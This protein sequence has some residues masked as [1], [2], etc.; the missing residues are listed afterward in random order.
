MPD[1]PEGTFFEELKRR[2]VFRVAI[3][4]AIASWLILQI[5]DVVVPMLGLPEWVG[6]MVLLMLIVSFPIALI[7]AWA[8]E[9]TPEGVRLERNVDRSQSITAQTGKKLNFIIIGALAVALGISLYLNFGD[10]DEEVVDTGAA[11][12]AGAEQLAPSI[13]VLPFANRSANENDTFFVDGMHDD[14][15]TQLAKIPALK[16]IS[17]TSVL[18]YR[19][20][21]KPMTIIG[22]ELGVTTIVEG[23]VQRAGDRIRI[24][25]QLI[26]AAT[27]EHIWAET[28]NR[29]LTAANIFEIQEEVT[30]EIAAAL[31]AEL[32]P[33]DQQRLAVIPTQNLAAYEAYLLGRQLLDTRITDLAI[34]AEVQFNRAIEL[35]PGFDMARVALTETYII[36]NNLGLTPKAELLEQLEAFETWAN[37]LDN[38]SGE[39]YNVLA[40]RHEYA[41]NYELAEQY[42]VRA[43]ELS[44]EYALARHWLALYYSN[45]T[46][47]LDKAIRIYEDILEVDPLNEIVR[48]NLSFMYMRNG[49]IEL[50]EAESKKGIALVGTRP[51]AIRTLGDV[52]YNGLSDA[53]AAMQLYQKATQLDPSW[54]G[55]PAVLY[56]A[57]GD[58]EA[59]SRWTAAHRARFPDESFGLIAEINERRRSGDA[60]RAVALALEAFKVS[61]DVMSPSFPLR[62]LQDEYVRQG[63]AD[64]LL[65]M[66]AEHYPELLY[67][68]PDVHASNI[69]AAVRLI[70]V[71]RKMA[72]EGAAAQLAEL[73]LQYARSRKTIDL[74]RPVTYAA[75]VHAIYGRTEEAVAELSSLRAAG[76]VFFNAELLFGSDDMAEL[77]A[78][79][80]F[81]E[82]LDA[83]NREVAAQW[84]R[85]RQLEEAGKIARF[86]EQLS[87][88]TIDVSSLIE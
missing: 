49:D 34:E 23:G 72:D 13:A 67:Q 84:A 68:D 66:Y 31:H 60:E 44:P 63:R 36:Q 5:V 73:V 85:I 81:Q 3:A 8:L 20:T 88:I 2:N 24:N 4:F 80:A 25:V 55:G 48:A 61:R 42:Y 64:E 54:G 56:G 7:L 11:A 10:S 41:G 86:P 51:Q 17:R 39:V 12:V 74:Q 57:I 1:N 21:E 87:S 79:A 14:L 46:D 9:L 53:V 40:A 58:S 35:D 71:H 19:D 15:L 59:A 75:E 77:R 33:E 37:A 32:T 52:F 27:D 30:A 70:S 28:Y 50:A 82:L 78:D 76:R 69:D 26:K 45:F 38:K 47:E 6:K 16:V 83:N 65:Q 22:E 43:T 29:E 18:Q 62:V